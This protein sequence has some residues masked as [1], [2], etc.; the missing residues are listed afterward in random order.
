METT[1]SFLEELKKYFK[2]TSRE[3]ILKDWDKSEEF[4]S[5]GSTMDEF[6]SHT[7]WLYKLNLPDSSND[8]NITLN[9]K[10]GNVFGFFC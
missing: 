4:D 2:S 6:L 9:K 7:D 10:P 3:K 8:Y 1:M 5:V